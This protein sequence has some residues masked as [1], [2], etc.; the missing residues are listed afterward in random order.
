MPWR[1]D[2]QHYLANHVFF[3]QLRK[4]SIDL[5]GFTDALVALPRAGLPE[6]VAEIPIE[7]NNEIVARIQEHLRVVSEHATEFAEQV[8]R[9]LA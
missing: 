1:L 4:R 2:D 6:I 9:R 5:D 3:R 7:W 8:R